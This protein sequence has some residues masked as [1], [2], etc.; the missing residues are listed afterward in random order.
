MV[1]HAHQGTTSS[2]LTRLNVNAAR[3]LGTPPA[4]YAHLPGLAPEHLNDDL[5]RPPALTSIRIAELATVH[6]PWTEVA[7]VMTRQSGIG[8]L[9][10][11]DY[12]FTSAPT[13]LEGM[14]D[15]TAY[16]ATVVDTSTDTVRISEDGD[17]VTV[18]HLNEAHLAHEAA[19]AVRAC[20][21]GLYHRRLGEAAQRTLV[22]VRVALAAEAPARHDALTELY[23]TRDIEFEV[24]VS[25]ITFRTADLNS[26]SPQAQPG[27]SGVLR[28]HAEQ[29]LAGAV[30]LRNWL[31]LFRAA[32]TSLHD[33][34]ALTLS[35]AA[36]RMAVSTRTLQRRLDEHGTTWSSEV[37]TVRREHITRL[38]HGTD[39]SID[40]IAARSDY[41]D[42]RAL[43]RAV[44][45]WYSTTPAALRR[46]GRPHG[47][48]RTG[49]DDE[50]AAP[51]PG[52]RR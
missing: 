7:R 24:P 36:G 28:R 44:H 30:P 8:S 48:A 19:S 15:A 11:W 45:R 43:R 34:G 14:R 27:L 18:T 13:P 32:L 20:A 52:A 49:R 12:L 33:E 5:C 22:P 4:G 31:D 2:A 38:L 29:T 17:E 46:T 9:G 26:P 10:V 41:A 1:S 47:T 6:A 39:L 42:A 35:A 3:L 40:A 16:L 37:E 50:P 23:G 21:L 51:G 25:S